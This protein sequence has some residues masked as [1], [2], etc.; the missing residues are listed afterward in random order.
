MNKTCKVCKLSKDVEEFS[1]DR[2]AK[3]GHRAECKLCW[4]ATMK[5]YYATHP[6]A[7]LAR[8]EYCKKWREDIKDKVLAHYGA[9]CAC[10]GETERVFLTLD[11]VNNDGADHRRSMGVG[12]VGGDK[13]W[14]WL[15]ATNFAESERLQ[16]L[17]QEEAW[18][19][20]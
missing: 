2:R 8:S 1:K 16:I 4:S 18:K 11:H 10:C 19:T 3:D 20:P 13:T 5:E 15:V 17:C 7:R 12:R 9:R 6:D 14:R